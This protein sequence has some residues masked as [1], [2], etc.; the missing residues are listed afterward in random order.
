VLTK[1]LIPSAVVKHQTKAKVFVKGLEVMVQV[2]RWTGLNNHHLIA[3]MIIVEGK[4]QPQLINKYMPYNLQDLYCL[5][6]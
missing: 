3:V 4:V 5:S 1:G 2:D 6:P